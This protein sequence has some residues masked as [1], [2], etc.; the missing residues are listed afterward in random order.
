MRLCGLFIAKQIGRRSTQAQLRQI[1]DY[2]NLFKA[3]LKF[4][5]QTRQFWAQLGVGVNITSCKSVL[6][7]VIEPLRKG[8]C[9]G[10]QTIAGLGMIGLG[11]AQRGTNGTAHTLRKPAFQ[12]LI[13]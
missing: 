1:I 8:F 2:I 9:V 13:Y 12:R 7:E 4:S 10:N 6:I 3:T 11:R 5:L